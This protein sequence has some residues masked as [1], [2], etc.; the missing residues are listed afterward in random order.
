MT[1]VTSV[2]FDMGLI[3][4]RLYLEQFNEV[5]FKYLDHFYSK[6]ILTSFHGCPDQIGAGENTRY[7]F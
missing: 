4:F 3:F 6:K 7:Y 5:R 2:V 1:L